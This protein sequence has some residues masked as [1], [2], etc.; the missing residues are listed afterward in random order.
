MKL[1]NEDLLWLVSYLGV[2]GYS[3][4]KIEEIIKGL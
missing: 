4:E 3:D 1:N 2:N